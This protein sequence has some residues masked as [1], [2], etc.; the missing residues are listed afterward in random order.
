MK[1]RRLP[2][3]IFILLFSLLL[4]GCDK[5]R[6]DWKKTQDL[7]A[8]RN[9]VKKIIYFMEVDGNYSPGGYSIMSFINQTSSA[10]NVQELV[11]IKVDYICVY[12]N[13]ENRIAIDLL[14]IE[15]YKPVIK[16]TL[17]IK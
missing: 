5:D 4:A 3:V 2:I 6:S 16:Q 9:D 17:F 14:R 11:S 15:K 12:E 10:K 8:S 7:M 13:T 1:S